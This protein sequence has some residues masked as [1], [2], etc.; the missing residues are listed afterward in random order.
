MTV[1][2]IV[3]SLIVSGAIFYTIDYALKKDWI[4]P[5]TDTLGYVVTSLILGFSLIWGIILAIKY[6]KKKKK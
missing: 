1:A 6:Y 2:L 3:L 5:R 4:Q